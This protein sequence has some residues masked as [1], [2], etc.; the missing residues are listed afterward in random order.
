MKR[1]LMSLGVIT[2]SVVIALGL[3]FAGGSN[4]AT[5]GAYP[6]M[7]SCA[8]LAFAVQWL[9]FIPSYIYQTELYYD[10][11]G[12]VT[13]IAITAL[14]LFASAG[15]FADLAPRALLLATMVL[16]W[17]LRLGPFLFRRVAK[18]GKDGRFDEIK[19]SW[20]RL[21]VTWTLQGLWV[22]VTM[23]AA[24]AAITGSQ[25]PKLDNWALAGALLWMLGF[26]IEAVADAQKTAFNRLSENAGKFINVG[27]WRWSRHPNYF[28]EIL[29]WVGVA[30]VAVPSLQ[31]WQWATVISPIFVWVLLTR[32]SGVPL[33]ERR[34]DQKWGG[35]PGYEYY[36]A[37]TPVLLLRPPAS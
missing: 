19:T 31:S 3:A 24:L 14:A 36:K 18:A 35:E 7:L 2:F 29:L 25:A 26:G 6:A 1:T 11:T 12:S 21:L 23:A 4:G 28:G 37:T 33:L 16:L 8:V 34:A 27:L 17:T 22:F 13:Y 20:S 32:V 15:S 9:V 30:M 10:L 5:L